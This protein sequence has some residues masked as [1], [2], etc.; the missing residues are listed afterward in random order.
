MALADVS[1]AGG[2]VSTRLLAQRPD[3]VG[4]SSRLRVAAFVLGAGTAP[5]IALAT[6]WSGGFA[7]LDVTAVLT[8]LV[9]WSFA[10][11]GFVAWDRGLG[12]G[13]GP[14][15]LTLGLWWT[16]GQLMQ[17]PTFASPLVNSVGEV[18]RLA[19]TFGFVFLLLAFPNA[20]LASRT[21]RLLAAAVFFVA[22]PMQVLWLLFLGGTE[23]R[24]A[25]L[26]WPSNSA[27]NAIDR[28]QRV[29]WLVVALLLVALLAKRWLVAGL[30]L[31][32]M[33][34]PTVAGAL[35]VLAFSVLVIVQ[36]FRP[37]PLFLYWL[38]LA[39]YTLVPLALLAS[40]LRARLARASV[41]DLLVEL[42]THAAPAEVRDALARALRDPHLTLAF[43]L[44]EYQAYADLDGRPVEPPVEGSGRVVTLVDVRGAH[45]AAL[46]HDTALRDEP[47]LLDAVAAAAGIALE[48]GRLQADLRGRLEELRGS[49]ARILEAGLR[50]RQRLERD[51]HDGAQQRLVALSLEVGLLCERLGSD[52]ET[53]RVLEQVRSELAASLQELH[54]LARGIHPAVVVGHGLEV[55]LESMVAR[56]PLPVRL[57]V[58]LEGRVSQAIE[59][60]TYYVVSEG[61]T[62]VAKHARASGAT[63][64]V[65]RENG[66]LVIEIVDDGAGGAHTDG[67]SGIRGLADRVE[68]LG[69]HLRVWSP[70]GG[71]TRLR[72]EIP[73]G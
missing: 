43:W 15:L 18:W 63:V 71:G 6:V 40:V 2:R 69:G 5:S 32:R 26:V 3:R 14:L 60:A 37:V 31:R 9:A 51:L 53:S 42:R 67:G 56:A 34:R 23:P 21:D 50:E 27:A 33:L 20:R 10:T 16:A 11:S 59:L 64:G 30:P 35:A 48:N 45:V 25:F 66:G 55:A 28:T 24:N 22:V 47:R 57:T 73:C 29:L 54:E 19:W 46:V 7:A 38:V 70:Y 72:A 61:L 58:D 17:P 41:A 62:N 4:S 12:S 1:L 52:S 39:S 13:A 8:V 49:R 68:A 65:A 36:A 44:P